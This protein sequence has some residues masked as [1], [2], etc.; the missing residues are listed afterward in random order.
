[1]KNK[2]IIKLTISLFLL[3][4]L[5]TISLGQ[6][7]SNESTLYK[8]GR[9]QSN[10]SGITVIP[11]CWE[12]PNGYVTETNWVKSAIESAWEYYANIDFQG[13]GACYTNSKG[14]RIL[15]EDS[16]PRSR[17][18]RWMDGV[19]NGMKL[20]FTFN[21]FSRSYC[22]N[23]IKF[24]IEA[25]GVHEFGHALG[26]AHEQDRIDSLCSKDQDL[27]FPTVSV[28]RYDKDSVM[29]YCNKEW[30]NGGKLSEYD[31]QGVQAIYGQKARPIIN[32]GSISVYNELGKDQ[33]WEEVLISLG[34]S[35]K[36]ITIS[37][38]QPK[39]TIKWN[40]SSSGT[41]CFKFSTK[42]FHTNGKTYTGYGQ[43]CYTLTRGK[44]YSPL[45]LVRTSW[46]SAGYYNISLE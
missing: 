22:K 41:Y 20:N 40:F 39:I 45:S 21:N 24:C 2:P 14:V 11:V 32:D 30:N 25:I 16:H 17:V 29:N 46:N 35:E 6:E 15:I 31:I 42:A 44:H 34:G 13:W 33:I 9:W 43:K 10:S 7:P 28:T 18:G 23:N 19:P 36:K 3:F 1:M 4:G 8:N 5:Y 26:F 37:N 12:N 38:Q 27:S